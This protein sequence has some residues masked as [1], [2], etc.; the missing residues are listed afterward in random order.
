MTRPGILTFSGRMV[1]VFNFTPDDVDV[2]DIAHALSQTCRYGGHA[3]EFYSVAQHSVLLSQ[4]V[5][6]YLAKCALLHDAAEAYIGDVPRPIKH[7]MPVFVELDDKMTA[8]IL[9]KFG[10][11]PSQMEELKQY[12][13]RICIDE[14]NQLMPVG[15]DT[16]IPEEVL[17]EPLGVEIWSEG[18]FT[19]ESEFLTRFKEL[20]A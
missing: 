5:P 16:Y 1:D 12:D 7:R 10:V 11:D 19:A 15:P 6:P 13:L 9:K 20:F 17:G 8:I 4:V 14:M 2:T 18:P 3:C